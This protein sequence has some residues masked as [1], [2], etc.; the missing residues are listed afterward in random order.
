MTGALATQHLFHLQR[1]WRLSRIHSTV[2]QGVT[3]GY[4]IEA[5]K[6]PGQARTRWP[7]LGGNTLGMM[8]LTISRGLHTVHISTG[9]GQMEAL[10]LEFSW[11]S[12]LSHLSL[13]D[14]SLYSFIVINYN[15][16]YNRLQ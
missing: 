10:P 4:K 6:H 7:S 14:F 12:T 5:S 8:A 16:E 11:D 1:T 13:S 9:R 15:Y 3:Q 2:T